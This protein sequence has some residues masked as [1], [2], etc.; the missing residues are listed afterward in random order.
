MRTIEVTTT[1]SA[2]AATVWSILVRGDA[3]QE[4]NP[5]ITAVSGALEDG[6]RPRLRIAP[7]GRRAMTFRPLVTD[8]TPERRLA[9]TGS[10]AVRGLCDAQHEFRL[11]PLPDGSTVLVQRETFRG[12]LVPLLGGMLEPTRRGFEAM[13]TALGERAEQSLA[14]R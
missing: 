14:A 10:I 8:A 11:E 2:P 13:N 12:L 7:P 6:G 1:I 5:F 9:W 3:Y 4:W